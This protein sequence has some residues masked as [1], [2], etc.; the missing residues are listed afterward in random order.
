MR[1]RGR[2]RDMLSAFGELINNRLTTEI[3][4][5]AVWATRQG[6]EG[7]KP[8]IVYDLQLG[9]GS[10]GSA[11]VVP[12]L[13]VVNCY[14]VTADGADT[15]AAQVIAALQGWSGWNEEVALMSC[16]WTN[17]QKDRD[18]EKNVF[19]AVL[20]FAATAITGG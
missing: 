10:G 11:P 6:Q 17:S 2:C 13:L 8:S 16:D 4:N 1:S 3:A 20:T 7:S 14:D 9:A 18:D 15:V 19:F 12:A 5:V